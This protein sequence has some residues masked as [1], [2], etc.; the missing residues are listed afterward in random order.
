M[1]APSASKSKD[2]WLGYTGGV[3][4]KPGEPPG[5]RNVS[6]TMREVLKAMEHD[7]EG[8][9]RLFLV[10]VDAVLREVDAR[11]RKHLKIDFGASARI[12]IME[13]A[14]HAGT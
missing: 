9:A 7:Q 13:D 2:R 3:S 14:S 6:G 12:E 8:H 1:L 10:N 4:S 11:A 5:G